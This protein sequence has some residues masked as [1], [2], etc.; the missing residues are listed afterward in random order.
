MAQLCNHFAAQRD[1]ITLVTLAPSAEE[2]L[3][4]VQ[5]RET[6]ASRA[7]RLRELTRPCFQSDRLG[8]SPSENVCCSSPR[9]GHFVCRLDERHGAF[10]RAGLASAGDSVRARRS[11]GPSSSHVSCRPKSAPPDISARKVGSSFKPAVRRRFSAVIPQRRS[12][13]FPIRCRQRP[14]LHGRPSRRP[15]AVIASLAWDGSITRKASIFLSKASPRLAA[16][17]PDWDVAIFGQDADRAGLLAQ[18][19]RHGLGS[20]D[21]AYG[22]H[23]RYCGR[24]GALTYHGLPIP[25]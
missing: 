13:R 17:F 15:I 19:E 20:P 7:A 3:R 10:G 9:C 6:V 25:L 24:V 22:C 16:R 18:I 4:F 14:S 11:R 12:L 1:D 2:P 8:R 21:Q 5:S 23:Q